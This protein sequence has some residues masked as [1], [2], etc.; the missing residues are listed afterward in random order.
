[1]N[2]MINNMIKLKD[3][4]KEINLREDISGTFQ[5]EIEFDGQDIA[6]FSKLTDL[7]EVTLDIE[8]SIVSGTRGSEDEPP[9]GPRVEILEYEIS[10][11][12]IYGE[13]GE[14]RE[15]D[16]KFLHP[17]IEKH[18]KQLVDTW[19]RKYSTR[20]ED[21]IFDAKGRGDN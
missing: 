8:Y 1:M 5:Y 21:T 3:I 15:I 16:I 13:N 6:A 18:I 20:V 9:E 4:L 12:I 17:I 2:L 10:N 11:I 14:E 7:I 19:M